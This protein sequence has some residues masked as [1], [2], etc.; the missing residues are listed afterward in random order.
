[1]AGLSVPEQVAVLAAGN[2]GP[3]CETAPVPLSA[4]DNN[5]HMR[6]KRMVQELKAQLEGRP[7]PTNPILIPPA[8]VVE[9]RSTDI[10][11]V[12]DARVAAAIRFMWDHYDWPI[13][14]DDVALQVGTSRTTIERAFRRCLGRGV[15][16]E[17]RR[18]RLERCKELLRSTDM[19]IP[20]I[21]A[22][23]GLNDKRYLHRAFKETFG[24]TP[25]HYRVRHKG[26]N[27]RGKND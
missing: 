16:A 9:R 14:V 7:S 24:E 21:T 19:T 12:P 27:S 2:R 8:G 18:K 5:Q 22:A 23:I 26:Q 15:I 10:L 11:A 13:T 6:G 1:M 3:A 20:E 4:I 17:L 25:R